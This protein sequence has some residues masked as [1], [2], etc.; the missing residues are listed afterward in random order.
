MADVKIKKSW[1][2]IALVIIANVFI[3]SYFSKGLERFVT[4]QTIDELEHRN[5]L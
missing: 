4:N 5:G 2:A 3:F 1:I